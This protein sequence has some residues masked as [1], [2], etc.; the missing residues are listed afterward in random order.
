MTVGDDGDYM[1]PHT[2]YPFKYIKYMQTP[3]G[4]EMKKHLKKNELL[5]AIRGN[6]RILPEDIS[7]Y[8]NAMRKVYKN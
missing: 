4:A 2:A 1:G 3:E 6:S 5:G 7:N 8:K